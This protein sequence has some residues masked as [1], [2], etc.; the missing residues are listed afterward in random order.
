M[1]RLGFFSI[2]PVVRFDLFT[3]INALISVRLLKEFTVA[4]QAA[5]LVTIIVL[6]AGL[7]LMGV[8]YYGER[9][10]YTHLPL[11]GRPRDSLP[12]CF[13]LIPNVL[14]F[15]RSGLKDAA[16]FNGLEEPPR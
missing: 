12:Q 7:N 15:K 6:A 9:C 13:L 14:E 4:H 1:V 3:D 8:K 2:P 16:R 11:N 5:Y 10:V